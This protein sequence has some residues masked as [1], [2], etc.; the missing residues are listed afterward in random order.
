MK[1]LLIASICFALLG[2]GS[3]TGGP[4]RG[5]I[6]GTV[7][8]DDVLVQTGMIQF[9]PTDGNEGPM[10]G[11]VITHGKY[12]IPQAKGPVVGMNHI[13]IRGNRKTGKIIETRHGPTEE[14]V[15]VVPDHYNK[16]STLVREVK[17]GKNEFHFKLSSQPE[18]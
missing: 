6:E 8:V 13:Q 11:A 17:A 18:G 12:A 16:H 15:P 9:T 3:T 4:E 14:R 5:S 1:N 10:S 7:T 2:C